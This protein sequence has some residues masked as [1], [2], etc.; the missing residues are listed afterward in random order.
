MTDGSSHFDY[1]GSSVTLRYHIAP[2]CLG[3][4]IKMTSAK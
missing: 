3:K 1:E 2:H 4:T